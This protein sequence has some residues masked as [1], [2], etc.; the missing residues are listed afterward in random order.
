MR[1]LWLMDE[2]WQAGCREG[3]NQ[4]AG[5]GFSHSDLG[6]GVFRFSVPFYITPEVLR[7][8]LLLIPNKF[9]FKILPWLL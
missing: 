4:A 3:P 8:S 5:D 6:K 2:L 7:P 9:I 1:C